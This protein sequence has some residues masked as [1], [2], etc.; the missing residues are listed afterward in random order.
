MSE[1][2]LNEDLNEARPRSLVRSNQD[3][4]LSAKRL[5]EVCGDL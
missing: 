1:R 5:N 4:E 2:G 3:V